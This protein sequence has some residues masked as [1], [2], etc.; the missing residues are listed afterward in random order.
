M[1]LMSG[2]SAYSSVSVTEYLRFSGKSQNFSRYSITEFFN[3]AL[4]IKVSEFSLNLRTFTGLNLECLFIEGL[5][6]SPISHR[7]TTGK[8]KCTSNP[9]TCSSYESS[10][11]PVSKFSGENFQYS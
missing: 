8:K 7:C 3:D 11:H 10:L 2:I 6:P 5:K 1:K 9:V 4:L